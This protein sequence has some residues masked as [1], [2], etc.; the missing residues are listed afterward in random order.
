V[1]LLNVQEEWAPQV[2]D[3]EVER[4]KRLHARAADRARRRPRAL[5]KAAD[6]PFEDRMVVGRPAERIVKV[7]RE[8]RSGQ[9]V[10]GMRGLGAIA[11]IVIGSV[12]MKVVQLADVPVTL[13][14]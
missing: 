2:T 13:V 5:L 1:V 4:G 12:S 10:M 8:R 14:K 7:A 11:R 9:I 6:I 3:E